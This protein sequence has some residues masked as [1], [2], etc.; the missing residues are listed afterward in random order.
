MSCK[1]DFAS[2]HYVVSSGGTVATIAGAGGLSALD[3]AS[4]GGGR[5][6]LGSIGGVSGGSIV[7]ALYAIGMTPKELLHMALEEDFSRHITIKGGFFGPLS[8]M[9]QL[10]CA[11]RMRI[12]MSCDVACE[13]G[14]MLGDDVGWASTGLFGTSRLGQLIQR[15]AYQTGLGDAWPEN[16]WNMAT[17]KDGSQIVFR[18]DGAHKISWRKDGTSEITKIADK[19]PPLPLSVRASCAIPGIMTAVEFQNMLL[20]DGA[21]SRDGFCPVGFMIRH[22][23]LNP[24]KII[25]CRVG[26]DAAH[27]ILGPTQ[28]TIRRIWMIHPDYH[29]GPETAGVITFRPPIDHIHTLKFNLSRDEKWL[30][31]LIAFESCVKT[32]AFHGLLDGDRLIQAR[33]MFKEIGYWRD[34]I[35]ATLGEKQHLADRAE[36]VFADNGLF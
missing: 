18:L 10:I 1:T 22:F 25:A 12:R 4:G 7:A 28:R 29:W 14:E 11:I 2:Y 15:R 5:L 17:L 34:I 3:F 27:Y 20:F 21:L 23:G 16:Y 33:E 9:K 26:E 19:P 8:Q 35:P 36:K 31:I 24:Q 32:L 6:K 13:H 30:A